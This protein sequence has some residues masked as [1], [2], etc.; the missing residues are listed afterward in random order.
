MGKYK[1]FNETRAETI[2]L[3]EWVEMTWNSKNKK[4]YT[5]FGYKYTYIGDTF[6]CRVKDLSRWSRVKILVKCP[7]C[8]DVRETSYGD[9]TKTGHTLCNGCSNT[10][11]LSEKRFGRW[12]VIDYAG[13]GWGAMWLC[14]CECGN[15]KS[16]PASALV[17]GESKSCGCYK[18]D[19]NHNKTGKDNPNWRGGSVIR[20]CEIC[21][22]E[23]TVKRNLINTS[24]FCSIECRGI[25]CSE[26]MSGENS[27]H[28]NPDLTE[29]DRISDRKYTEYSR[30]VKNVMERDEWVCQCCGQYSGILDV[31]HLFSYRH[32][33]SLRTELSNGV[34][35]CRACH[36]EFHYVFMGHSSI[37]CT[38]NDFEE[39]L[40][41]RSHSK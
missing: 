23:Y 18:E 11:D 13:S 5:S 2:I 16:V 36:N 14:E 30:W 37:P 31:H 40:Y 9:F 19:V 22:N 25:W 7:V 35:L 34:T 29:E 1:R 21:K 3:D 10:N 41:L 15:K 17:D 20:E 28:W 12:T 38:P 39:W 6:I 26:N 32:Y 8:E 4:H 27:P 24:R 33:P